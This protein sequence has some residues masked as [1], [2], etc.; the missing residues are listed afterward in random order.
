MPDRRRLLELARPGATCSR[1]TPRARKALEGTFGCEFPALFLSH[2]L[3]HHALMMQFV[4][5][6]V[7]MKGQIMDW[8]V[9]GSLGDAVVKAVT[10]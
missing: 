2:V 9:L 4:Q 8:A 5:E 10:A 1:R 7:N 3:Y 6:G